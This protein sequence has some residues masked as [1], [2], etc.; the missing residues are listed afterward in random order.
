MEKFTIFHCKRIGTYLSRLSK[1]VPVRICVSCEWD[2]PR[3][4]KPML[5]NC[6]FGVKSA[7]S[8]ATD[9]RHFH[10]YHQHSSIR[11]PPW[12][13]MNSPI[14]TVRSPKTLPVYVTQA[15]VRAVIV[16]SWQWPYDGAQRWR[17][18]ERNGGSVKDGSGLGIFL[19][20]DEWAPRP[21][22]VQGL[23]S[24]SCVINGSDN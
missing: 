15:L 20:Q 18:V 10:T 21:V 12:K 2:E 14:S 13:L 3:Q 9:S 11:S 8:H 19:Q 17:S 7:N 6:D 5:Q 24:S 4:Q 22:H 23:R 1:L 16:A